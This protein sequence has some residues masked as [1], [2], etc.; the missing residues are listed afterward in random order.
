M[1]GH[2]VRRES[3]TATN[4]KLPVSTNGGAMNIFAVKMQER[5]NFQARPIAIS[6]DSF[7]EGDVDDCRKSRSRN[8]LDGA[9]STTGCRI[10]SVRARHFRKKKTL[11]HFPRKKCRR[12]G[13]KYE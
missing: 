2:L 6:H 10:W 8:T 11:N 13:I 12:R 3:V 1:P 9:E 7:S 4:M 5:D